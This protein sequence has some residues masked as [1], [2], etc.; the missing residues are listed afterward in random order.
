MGEG[1]LV[2]GYSPVELP[3]E[4]KLWQFVSRSILFQLAQRFFRRC[5]AGSVRP[6]K[7]FCDI[8]M[9][10]CFDCV[11]SMAFVFSNIFEVH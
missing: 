11:A 9:K 10:H 8:L 5:A 1:F 2:Q 6:Q 4:W 3:L 7:K